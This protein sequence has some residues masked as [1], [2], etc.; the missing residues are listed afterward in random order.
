[1]QTGHFSRSRAHSPSPC[2]PDR[3]H[4]RRQS[5]VYESLRRSSRGFRPAKRLDRSSLRV[6][7]RP[8]ESLV[9]EPQQVGPAVGAPIRNFIVIRH[10]SVPDSSRI[11]SP[12]RLPSRAN[13]IGDGEIPCL[14]VSLRVHDKAVQRRNVHGRAARIERPGRLRQ[15]AGFLNQVR[16]VRSNGLDGDAR[17]DGGAF[18]GFRDPFLH[19]VIF[20]QAGRVARIR[21]IAGLDVGLALLMPFARF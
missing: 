16:K 13:P 10:R 19:P 2:G 6:R 11:H 12:I 9:D 7:L 8:R 3:P 21:L 15:V 4:G 17:V 1:M 20:C 18:L 5:L 14:P